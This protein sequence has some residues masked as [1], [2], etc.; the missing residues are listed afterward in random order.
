MND[1]AI[2]A[3]GAPRSNPIG[4]TEY[5]VPPNG[6]TKPMRSLPA[7]RTSASTCCRP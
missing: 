7:R 1:R 6:E 3:L 2:A 5:T 4:S